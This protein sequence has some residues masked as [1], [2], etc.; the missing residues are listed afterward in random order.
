[1]TVCVYRST[2]AGA[3]ALTLN[4][5]AGKLIA[6]IDACLVNGYSAGAVSSITRSG[7]V[8]TV[9]FSDPHGLLDIN[10]LTIAGA[11]QAEYN[12]DHEVT[13]DSPT[14]VTF[15]VSGTPASPA[16]GTI[17][18]TKAGAGWTKP[19]SGTNL[20]VYKQG[21]GSNQRY[22]R[23]DD[24]GTTSARVVPYESMSDVNTGTNGFPTEAQVSGGLH[25]P[26]SSAS[27]NR[28]WI[29]VATEKYF[30]LHV[31]YSG[32]VTGSPLCFF[33]DFE[34]DLSTAD[35][36][37]TAVSAGTSA[38]F[39]S[40][41]GVLSVVGSL[42]NA[43]AGSYVARSYT[44]TGGSVAIGKT[45]NS[46]L[47][48]TAFYSGAGG[49][50]YPDPVTNGLLH[51]LLDVTEPSIGKRGNLPGILSPLHNLPLTH[52][53]TFVGMGDYAGKTYLVLTGH[54]SGQVFIEISNT[55]S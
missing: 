31:N 4:N 42:P 45:N 46:V 25:F 22:L 35:A 23:V 17:T 36:Y 11:D 55:V 51:Y 26:K 52:L 30:Y 18:A 53:D 49:A 41:H 7:S 5:T 20:A 19:Y 3:A 29:L 24:T 27:T 37:N 16:T 50:S 33:G 14:A 34:S 39:G 40:G 9:T 1:M 21:T 10:R 54:S 32:T 12:G 47:S 15:N 13:V 8:A 28:D 38:N 2:D 48:A 6:I 44:Q 43:T